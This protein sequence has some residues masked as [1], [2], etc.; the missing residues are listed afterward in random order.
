MAPV[1]PERRSVVFTG[2]LIRV[3]VEEW[4]GRGRREIVRHP[5][6]CA[7]VV[8]LDDE[9][10]VL[11]RQLREAVRREVLEIPA[12]IYDQEGESPDQ[13]MAREVA[14][15]TGCRVLDQRH[16]GAILTTPGFSDERI[17]LFLVR[18]ERDSPPEEG[19]EVV[20]VAFDDAVRMVHA[21]EIDDAKSA[22]ALLLAE[23]LL[24]SERA[25]DDG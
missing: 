24:R 17:D 4:R 25:S 2:H 10:V 20:E 22:V 15:E 3:E 1:E 11:I 16:L 5:G 19:I 21:G 23:H 14:E 9:R 6:S 18:G 13:T 7:G 8:L 12:G